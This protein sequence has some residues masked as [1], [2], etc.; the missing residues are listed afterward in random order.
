MPRPPRRLGRR[1]DPPGECPAGEDRILRARAGSAPSPLA[2][3]GCQSLMG[4]G[5][6]H[7][8]PPPT[9]TPT[10]ERARERLGSDLSALSLLETRERKET[11]VLPREAGGRGHAR[12]ARRG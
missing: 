11:G 3:R 6:G 8:E 10:S 1:H 12:A 7:E 5:D 2:L 4:V 9:H